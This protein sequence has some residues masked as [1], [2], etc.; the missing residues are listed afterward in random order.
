VPLRAQQLREERR[1][2]RAIG[3]S[4]GRHLIEAGG[5]GFEL[6]ILQQLLQ[7]FIHRQTPARV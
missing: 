1:D 7:V 5:D 6:Q 2:R 3:F 4:G